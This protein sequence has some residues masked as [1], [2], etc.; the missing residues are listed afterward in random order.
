MMTELTE[1]PVADVGIGLSEAVES[2][3]SPATVMLNQTVCRMRLL[4]AK[5]G[6][7]FAVIDTVYSKVTLG[8][9]ARESSLLVSGVMQELEALQ[10]LCWAAISSECREDRQLSFEDWS[11]IGNKPPE[12]LR[13][14]FENAVI[15][16]GMPDDASM[17]NIAKGER[18]LV[19]RSIDQRGDG[20]LP[21]V[22]ALMPPGFSQVETK[23]W[24]P[25]VMGGQI[26]VMLEETERP[27]VLQEI[28]AAELLLPSQSS[29][30]AIA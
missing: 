6:K 22:A 5:L 23:V 17:E 28:S 21:Q 11:D 19:I 29:Q 7:N 18:I 2:K 4:S 9:L 16:D 13:D 1:P 27:N 15:L 25:W 10:G 26:P 24:W 8:G 3:F 14:V 20:L 12:W 30:L